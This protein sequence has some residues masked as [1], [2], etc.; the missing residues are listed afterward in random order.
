LIK[1]LLRLTSGQDFS[2]NDLFVASLAF[3]QQS[4]SFLALS[5]SLSLIEKAV[6]TLESA[7]LLKKKVQKELTQCWI[8]QINHG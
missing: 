4:H 5:L 2:R 1:A 7:L 8:V 3:V 6:R